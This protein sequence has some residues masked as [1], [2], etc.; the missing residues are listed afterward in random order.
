MVLHYIMVTLGDFRVLINRSHFKVLL[1]FQ[2]LQI[3]AY[4]FS[5]WWE[6]KKESLF[7]HFTFIGLK[8]ECWR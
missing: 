1:K 6:E 3:Y 4:E 8:M 5:N 7:L 2:V